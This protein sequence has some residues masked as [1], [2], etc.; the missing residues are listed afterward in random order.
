MLSA[1]AF[2]G[3]PSVLLWS[4]R[5]ADNLS[6]GGISNPMEEDIPTLIAAPNQLTATLKFYVLLPTMAKQAG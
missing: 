1:A 6:G 3:G 4:A 2:L 5:R